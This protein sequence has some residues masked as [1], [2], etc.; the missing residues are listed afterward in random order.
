MRAV[1]ALLVAVVCVGAPSAV[2]ATEVVIITETA[3][4]P[5]VLRVPTGAQVDFVNRTGT[6]A[7]VEFGTAP[8]QHE[9]VQ[10]PSPGTIR[11]IFHRPG[12]HPY[13]VHVW[14]DRLPTTLAGIVE[15]ADDSKSER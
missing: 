11:V 14:R 13:I 3:L 4:D 6:N 9:L 2:A 15:V 1:L 7:H 12:R 8:R 5:P 10:V